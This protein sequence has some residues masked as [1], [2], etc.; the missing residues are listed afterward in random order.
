[1][2]VSRNLLANAFPGQPR[3][4][5]ELENQFADVDANSQAISSTVGATGAL[6][7]ATVITLSKNDVFTNER[8]LRAGPGVA[9]TA[10]SE[11]VTVKLSSEGVIAEGGAVHFVAQGDTRLILPITGLL[12]TRD[13]PETLKK[14]TLDAPFITSLGNFANDAAAA[15]GGVPLSGIYRNGSTLQVRVT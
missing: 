11:F 5:S 10:D 3:L 9:I 1:M 12:A 4:I 14:K 6:Q 15:G 2:G 8:V 7:D 13:N